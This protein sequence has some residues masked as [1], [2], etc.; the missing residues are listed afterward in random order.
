MVWG[1]LMEKKVK[2]S[3]AMIGRLP[4]DLSLHVTMGE[5]SDGIS[6]RDVAK[7]QVDISNLNSRMQTIEQTHEK[8]GER[9]F[10][11]FVAL[12]SAVGGGLVVA[13]ASHY[14]GWTQ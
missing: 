9:R 6:W 3:D 5:V 4:N 10:T 12:I 2:P 8:K 14:F 11:I 1:S 13:A 7:L